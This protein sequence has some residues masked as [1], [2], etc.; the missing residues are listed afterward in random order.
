M[1]VTATV[2]TVANTV[3]Q[4]LEFLS[5]FPFVAKA[6]NVAPSAMIGCN[7]PLVTCILSRILFDVLT[8]LISASIIKSAI[9]LQNEIFYF[10]TLLPQKRE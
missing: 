3:C 9:S 10:P 7:I 6:E 2:A 4:F 1:V 5:S 8:A